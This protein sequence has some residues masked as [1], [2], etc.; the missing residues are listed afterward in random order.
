MADEGETARKTISFG[1][2]N[3]NSKAAPPLRP[4]LKKGPKKKIKTFKHE[5]VVSRSR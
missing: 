1:T 5:M 4:A 2:S 3:V